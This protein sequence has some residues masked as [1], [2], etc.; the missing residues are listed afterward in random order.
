MSPSFSRRLSAGTSLA[1]LTIALAASLTVPEANAQQ[2]VPAQPGSSEIR[3]DPLLVEETIRSD[4][5]ATYFSG[6]ELKDLGLMN[7]EQVLRLTP[8]VNVNSSGGT[9]LNTI[10]IR[11]VGAMYPMNLTESAVPLIID[12]APVNSRHMSLGTLDAQS[13]EILKGPQGTW[14]GPGALAGAVDIATGRPTRQLDGYARAEY[15]EQN[16]SLLEAAIGGPLTE[17]LS[18]R[19][20]VRYSASDHWVTNEQ[21]GQPLAYPSDLAIRA[22]LLWDM[23][24]DTSALFT[25]EHEKVSEFPNLLVLRPYPASPS[26]SLPPGLYDDVGKTFD[27]LVV[28]IN[29][30]FEAARLTSITSYVN[31]SNTEIAAYDANIMFAQSGFAAAFWNQDEA[32]EKASTQDLRLSSRSDAPLSWVAGLFL[33][34]S[35]GNYDTPSN[36]Y[37]STSPKFRD[38]RTDTYALYGEMTYPVLDRLK[39][40]VGLRQNWANS[41]YNGEFWNMGT[42]TSDARTFNE[43]ATTG[44]ARLSYAVAPS[45]ELYATY[46]RGFAPGG[47]NI[48]ATQPADGEPYKGATNDMIEV[49]FNA[50]TADK[51]FALTAAAY[52]NWVS[53]NHLLSYNSVTYVVSSVNADTRSRGVEV[54]GRWR[55]VNGFELAVGVSYVD[56][57]ITSSVYGVGDGDIL[58]GY[59]VPDVSPWSALV[60]ASYNTALPS[61]LWLSDPRLKAVVSYNYVGGRPANPQNSLNLDAYQKLDVHLGILQGK[62]EAY[63]RADNLLDDMYDLYGYYVPTAGINYGGMARGRT[64]IAGISHRF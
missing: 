45:I 64:F 19:L 28:E 13:M 44:R 53:D 8:G 50:E 9:N 34:Q 56:A 61:F 63:V 46:A 36:T 52:S 58:A 26:V 48:Y 27:R 24:S 2:A 41:S 40:T 12:G 37:G 18:G 29:H 60:M 54:Q 42:A 15:G 33:Q 55:P 43:S 7:V 6:S 17:A 39:L 16:Q 30:D 20:A 38:F 32:Q 5:S 49:G 3:L 21:D 59:K 11:G 14:F 22:R 25:Y 4:Y 47:F 51:R 62:T 57:E 35:D 1:S 31:S 23:G 10:Y